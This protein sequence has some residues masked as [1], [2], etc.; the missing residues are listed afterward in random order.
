MANLLQF[1]QL[2]AA[3]CRTT[4]LG[5]LPW[6]YYL[7]FNSTTCQL[8]GFNVLGANSSILLI[9]LA[10]VD[11]LFRAAGVL[12]VAFIIYA[13][14]QYV[15]SQGAPDETAKAL[16]TGINALVGLGISLVAVLFVSFLG[17]QVDNRKG[18][19]TPIGLGL[20]SLPNPTGVEGSSL[21]QTA[22]GVTFGILGAI[23]FLIIVIAGMNY[24]FSQ[25]DPQATAKA[26]SAIIYAF[27]GLVIAILAESIVSFAV[28][29]HP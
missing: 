9:L 24:A 10:L 14:F 2:F 27:V 6:D 26:K 17:A 12:A 18:G 22:M 25:G 7:Q 3:G 28:N 23:A 5:F 29:T 8:Q 19:T 11:D 20:G 15:L 13:G 16:R 4:F 1:T 21:L